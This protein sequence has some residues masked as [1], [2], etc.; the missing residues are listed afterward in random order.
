MLLYNQTSRA[1][2]QH[3]AGRLGLSSAQ[4]TKSNG[5]LSTK[6]EAY[7][8]NNTHNKLIKVSLKKKKKKII[9]VKE[10]TTLHQLKGQLHTVM[11]TSKVS[12]WGKLPSSHFSAI[13]N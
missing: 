12:V 11:I 4:T 13:F 6:A 1:G 7:G 5:Q 8:H 10:G 2:N 3:R 9:I